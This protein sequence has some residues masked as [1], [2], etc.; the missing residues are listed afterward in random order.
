MRSLILV[1]LLAMV[2][3]KSHEDVQFRG[4]QIRGVTGSEGSFIT[5]KADAILFNPNDV[6]GK[7]RSIDV[8]VLYN[9]KE[10]AK[11]NQLSKTK[12]PA[13]AEF[14]VPLVMKVDMNKLNTDFLSQLSNI[15][16]KKGIELQFVG[17]VKVSIHGF[18]Y[19]VPV[20][21]RES[22]TF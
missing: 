5:V 16:S 20:D 6:K 18:G 17:N 12:V 15:L 21:H 1:F 13:N 22:I 2:S 9:G 8:A 10:V 7:V 19:K 14:K 4:I 11:V 3:C